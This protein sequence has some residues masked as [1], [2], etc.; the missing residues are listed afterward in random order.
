V[1]SGEKTMKSPGSVVIAAAALMALPAWVF[2]TQQNAQNNKKPV[3]SMT[4]DDVI[5]DR[6][7]QP[8]ETAS[9][10]RPRTS[11]QAKPADASG[12]ASAEEIAWRQA[13][14]KARALADSSQRAAEDTELRMTE[15]R[16]QLSASG[17]GPGDRNQTMN[18]LAATGDTLKRQKA[19]AREAANDLNKLLEDGRQ[20]GYREEEGPPSVSKK[21]EP[22]ED[23]YRTKFA[24][25]NQALQ[26]ADRRVQLYQNRI[27]E[28]NQRISGNSRTGDNFYIG[29]LQQDRDEAQHSLDQAREASQK[30]QADISAL[31]DQARAAGLPPGIFR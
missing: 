11:E 13:V 15:L 23:Y 14:K 4:S 31:K 6:P 9:A 18:D 17:Q 26:D 2:C 5:A 16:N 19:E 1:K 24:E 22:N 29:Q 10:D 30:A 25:L 20:K 8:A 28:L 27:N 3:P 12:K 21:G 7:V